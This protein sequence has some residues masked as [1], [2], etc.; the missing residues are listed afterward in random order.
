[1]RKYRVKDVTELA[2]IV[3]IGAQE[4]RRHTWE[5]RTLPKS[6][7]GDR[8]RWRCTNTSGSDNQSSEAN[9]DSDP[10]SNIDRQE[11]MNRRIMDFDD[12]DDEPIVHASSRRLSTEELI[13]DAHAKQAAKAQEQQA[14][15]IQMLASSQNA[16]MGKLAQAMDRTSKPPALNTSLVVDMRGQELYSLEQFQTIAH[17]Y[18]Y[19]E[20]AHHLQHEQ[21][22]SKV[23][24]TSKAAHIMEDAMNELD[25]EIE[26]GEYTGPGSG[27][28][29]LA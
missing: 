5:F 21:K 10:E 1:V 11:K 15:L 16:A 8:T 7:E 4:M 9:H 2:R 14:A 23:A 28:A 19:K 18:T 20:I 13:V 27:K 17:R 12:T 29:L 22:A 26:A 3:R 6:P 24:H 25:M